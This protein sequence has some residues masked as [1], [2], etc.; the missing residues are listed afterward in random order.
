M[1]Y[2]EIY[3]LGKC[4]CKC[5]Y[6]LN[7]EMECLREKN[8][9]HLTTHFKT[10]KNFDKFLNLCK[11]ENIEKIFLSSVTTEPMLY[12]YLYELVLYIKSKGFKVGIRTNGYFVMKNI[13]VLKELDEEISF[14]IN[15][16]N[17]NT[18]YKIC[19][20]SSL[21]NWDKIFKELDRLNKK[22]RVSIVVNNYNEKE[23]ANIL[24]TLTE[25]NCIN[26]VQ[27]R[28]I[29]KYYTKSEHDEAFVNVSKWL[30]DNAI[31]KSNYFES[32]IY[33]YK[34]LDVSLWND[35]FKKESII[36]LNYFTNGLLSDHN[37]IIPAYE[38]KEGV[39]E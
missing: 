32:E 6:C 1:I 13:D 19:K 26:Y 14:S 31:Y 30:K 18:N 28:R 5:F 21:P 11:E 12:K 25:Y 36:S 7:N 34:N 38:N 27:L 17:E 33:G 4:N 35:V 2:G 16:L 22:C 8:E 3:F 24:D 37:L 9:N 23:I 15:S 10:W 20:V 39:L 29:Y